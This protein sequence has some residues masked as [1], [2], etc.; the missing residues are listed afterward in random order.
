MMKAGAKAELLD[1]VTAKYM[2]HD[3]MSSNKFKSIIWTINI[4]KKYGELNFLQLI[5][6]TYRYGV[7][8]ISRKK[9][10]TILPD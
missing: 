7:N 10:V 8:V 3:S 2:I 6:A 4:L 9:A 1:Q 5:V